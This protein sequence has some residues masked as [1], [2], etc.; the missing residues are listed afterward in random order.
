MPLQVFYEEMCQD[1]QFIRTRRKE[2][3]NMSSLDDRDPRVTWQHLNT[4]HFSNIEIMKINHENH[5]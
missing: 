2:L 5:L 3:R 1:K 4:C